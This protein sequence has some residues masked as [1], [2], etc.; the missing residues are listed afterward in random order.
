MFSNRPPATSGDSGA[1]AFS[2][3][4]LTEDLIVTAT[5]GAPASITGWAIDG[6]DG[7]CYEIYGFIKA[8]NDAAVS[9]TVGIDDSPTNV[10]TSLLVHTGYQ[11]AATG[12][13]VGS[14]ASGSFSVGN[15]FAAGTTSRCWFF[16]RLLFTA[17]VTSQIRVYQTSTQATLK[18]GSTFYYRKIH[19]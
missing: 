13:Q 9:N 11:Q 6:V 8:V 18:A 2:S 17:T 4:T 7:D 16:G 15:S 10:Q 3:F 5:G 14:L 1:N 12:F 19:P